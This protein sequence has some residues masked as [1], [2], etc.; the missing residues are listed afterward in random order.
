MTK[1]VMAL[2]II[3]AIMMIASLVFYPAV[4]V[5]TDVDNGVTLITLTD[6]NV[7]GVFD[8]YNVGDGVVCIMIAN[9]PSTAT[10][11]VVAWV[12]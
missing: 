11:D 6:G 5:V 8:D 1:A 7:Y 4:G 10:D 9:N 2:S 12:F 3:L